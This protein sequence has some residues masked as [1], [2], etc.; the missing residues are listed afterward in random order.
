MRH[1]RNRSGPLTLDSRYKKIGGVC[2]GIGNYFACSN[3]TVRLLAIIALV[4]MPHITLP[5][6]GLA[7]LILDDEE[8]DELYE[9]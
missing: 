1:R 9:I 3:F 6:Y 7:Y 4:F 2:A 5:A 8:Q